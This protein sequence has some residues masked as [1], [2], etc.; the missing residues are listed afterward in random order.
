MTGVL[1][2]LSNPNLIADPVGSIAVVTAA[3]PD[4]FVI[5]RVL[6]DRKP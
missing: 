1:P 3:S 2:G 6:I 4:R 5:P